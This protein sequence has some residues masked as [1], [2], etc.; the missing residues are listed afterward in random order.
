MSAC[1]PPMS[2][3]ASPI[4]RGFGAWYRQ[5]HATYPLR[6]GFALCFM[7]GA[8]ADSI[9]QTTQHQAD[10]RRSCFGRLAESPM[11]F[12]SAYMSA[13]RSVPVSDMPRCL[14]ISLEPIL[15]MP[16]VLD[17]QRALAMAL[18]SGTFC[19][20]GYHWIFN[21]GYSVI[22]GASTTWSTAIGKT[23]GDALVVF[24]LMYMPT[25]YFFDEV[26]RS[27]SLQRIPQRFWKEM[28]SCMET[29]MYIWPIANMLM[30]KVVPAELKVTYI[31]AVSFGWLLILSYI[32]QQS[33]NTWR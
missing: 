21:R 15:D 1:V 24:P 12:G 17:M 30:F 22:F 27:G 2:R 16:R 33:Q 25:F 31:A 11:A 3:V 10:T 7:K 5:L 6:T 8:L 13:S 14:T 9:V 18:F 32:A 20:C 29:Y 26:V 23:I 4:W 28:G 19:G